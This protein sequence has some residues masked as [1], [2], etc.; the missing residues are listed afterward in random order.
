MIGETK[1]T[2]FTVKDLPADEFIKV[3]GQHLKKNNLIE[4][5]AWV[6]RV[7]LSTS[8]FFILFRKRTRPNWWWL[9]LLQSRFTCQKNLHQ[10]KSW[11]QTPLPHLRRPLQRKGQIRKT[12]T[13]R[14]QGY[15]MGTPTIGKT[16]NH[17][18]RQERRF[19]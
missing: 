3:F 12:S 7:K 4:R 10:T 2:F 14:Y 9:D 11:S 13:S 16:K 1:Q 17:Q 18:E 19:T 8:T 6:D 5:P 15:Q